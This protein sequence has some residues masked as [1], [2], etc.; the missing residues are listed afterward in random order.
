MHSWQNVFCNDKV[1]LTSW[2]QNI[3]FSVMKFAKGIVN[4]SDYVWI[5]NNNGGS[6]CTDIAT[7]SRKESK[8]INGTSIFKIQLWSTAFSKKL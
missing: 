3:V 4:K 1:L 6:N 8:I 7:K 5:F 2:K